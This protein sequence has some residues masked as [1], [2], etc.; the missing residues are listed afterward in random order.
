MQ[1]F[2][3][4]GMLTLQRT[5]FD[6]FY[7]Q[8]AHQMHVSIKEI[9]ARGIDFLRQLRWQEGAQPPL[10]SSNRPETFYTWTTESLHPA[11]GWR[12]SARDLARFGLLVLRKGQWRGQQFI[13]S[14]W[15]EEM[16]TPRVRF[17]KDPGIFGSRLGSF[18]YLWWLSAEGELFPHVSLPLGT[19]AS[20]GNGGHWV[21]ILP[22]LDMVIVH[23]ANTDSPDRPTIPRE[24]SGQ[25]LR[26]LFAARER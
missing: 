10:D 18:G 1:D 3:W 24:K 20:F 13:P 11:F 9:H 4:N 22:E 5:T 25:F 17:G 6:D 7:V 15:I 12:L 14:T 23:R 26:L 2:H 8:S 16:L 21:L 19:C